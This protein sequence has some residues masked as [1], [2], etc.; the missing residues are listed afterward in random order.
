MMKLRF[1]C[2]KISKN[3][4]KTHQHH[5]QIWLKPLLLIQLAATIIGGIVA[6][7]AALKTGDLSASVLIAAVSLVGGRAAQV[8]SSAQAARQAV[9]DTITQRLYDQTMDSQ[10]RLRMRRGIGLGASIP[11]TRACI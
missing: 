6:A 7:A 5:R 4:F 3:I 11:P 8:Y 1:D 9:Q 2:R 10:A